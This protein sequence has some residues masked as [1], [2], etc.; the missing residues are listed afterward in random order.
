MRDKFKPTGPISVVDLKL[1]I[2]NY[3]YYDQ[4]TSQDDCIQAMLED[5]GAY[6]FKLAEDI[7]DIGG[8]TPQ[9]I[10]VSKDDE[11]E[12]VVRDGNRRITALKLLNN[13]ALCHHNNTMKEKFNE[14][15]KI[16][17]NKNIPSKVDCLFCQ[18]ESLIK[19]YLLRHHSGLQEGKGQRQWTASNITHFAQDTG[20]KTQNAQAH[21]LLEWLKSKGLS[22][23]GKFPITT[24]QRMLDTNLQKTLGLEWRGKSFVCSDEEL[25]FDV[26]KKAVSDLDSGTK[27]VQD[28]F[29]PEL[30]KTYFDKILNDINKKPADPLAPKNPLSAL[31]FPNKKEVGNPVKTG[32]VPRKPSWD[33]KRLIDPRRTDLNIPNTTENARARNLFNELAKKIDV[34]QAPNA[35]SVL[36]RLLLEFSVD[37]YNTTNEIRKK[38]GDDSK[39]CDRAN[40]AAQ[41]MLKAGKINQK[42]V[43]VVNKIGDTKAIN[44]ANTL[45]KYVHCPDYHPDRQTLCT[46][47]DTMEFFVCHCWK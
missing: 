31:P 37:R 40:Q 1:D 11:G 30:R 38:G 32:I 21:E 27:K 44:S 18:D 24:F 19:T 13:P 33:R 45:N 8:L 35:A 4:L 5:H 7:I 25:L 47:W 23:S 17:R 9:P 12:W 16:S 20:G 14:L 3:R 29:T 6:I 41:H 36:L 34:R 22:L 15:F 43:E 42:Q 2:G 10:V 28:V 39:L 46:F 26:L